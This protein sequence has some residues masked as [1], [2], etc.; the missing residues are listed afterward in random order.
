MNTK[1]YPWLR[2]PATPL[3]THDP[4]FCIWSNSDQLHAGPTRHWTGQEQKLLGVAII[5]GAPYRF[6][7]AA[8]RMR[9]LPVLE[10][11]GLEVWP[12]STIAS[13]EGGGVRL[14]L[15]FTS[16]LL[17][18]DLDLMS[19]PVTYVTVAVESADGAAHNIQVFF[20][21]AAVISVDNRNDE[22]TWARFNLGDLRAL[23]ASAARQRVLERSGDNLRIEWGS[24]Y[25]SALRAD[26]DLWPG[27]WERGFTSLLN[28]GAFPTSDDLRQP[29][30]AA[31][32]EPHLCASMRFG[33]VS[34]QTAARTV[35]LAYDDRYSIEHMHTRLRP[36]WR[37]SG[38]EI[39]TLLHTAWQEYEQILQ[40]CVDFDHEMMA[41]LARAGGDQY[42]VM[43]ALA[44]RQSVAAHKLVS[45]AG[46]APFFF[47]KE[48]FSNGCI[49]T[50][51]ITYPSSPLFLLLNPEL[52]RG[53]LTPILDYAA[54]G[55]W[56][57]PYAPHDL[58]QY[59]LANGQVYGGGERSEENQ[60]P[61]EENGNLLIL[62]A[63]MARVDGN[64]E[65]ARRYAP[66][67]KQWA[68][69]LV[70]EGLDP[71]EQLCTDD[72]AGH[73]AH[74]TNLS[75]K[76]IVA[77]ACYAKLL[78]GMGEPT[79]AARY[80][81]L[82][83]S[84][85]AEWEQRALDDRHYRLTFD[86]PGTW[87]QKYNLVWDRLLGLGVFSPEVART[88]VAYY[89]QKQNRY[90]LPLDS[91]R[92]YTKLD[93]IFWCSALAESDD[94]FRAMIAP[95][96]TWANETPSRVPL[97]DWYETVDGT[98][99]HFQARSVVGGLFIKLLLD[100]PLWQKWLNRS[101]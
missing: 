55:R 54:S 95:T 63:L 78:E 65:Y 81:A 82:A 86:H 17:P 60:M 37:R 21:A 87:S 13:F 28:T 77:L 79:E 23:S 71:E 89:L 16:P 93:W 50:V 42:A 12:L 6:L 85:A 36:Y 67:L 7:G 8:Q 47:S 5:D 91:R 73:L 94:D 2:P 46:G 70:N 9:S 18:S 15:T 11:V 72:F 41:D 30:R 44:F 62:L 49:A 48:N 4:Y 45:G 19:R 64:V 39:D 98:A 66:L 58:G 99:H 83:R 97:S 40:R 92:E 24:L 31:D 26:V 52:L 27:Y 22:V 25:L 88:E 84:M 43:C 68:E 20:S 80:Q 29:R 33:P 75:V 35:M 3:V 69:Y 76:A 61:V 14:Q 1:P 57:F 100:E 56:R 38:M 96:W 51:D 32:E 34:S 53:M 59:P 90:G 74:N 101:R 10:Q